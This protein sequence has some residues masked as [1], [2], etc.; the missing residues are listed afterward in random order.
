MFDYNTI[1][2]TVE[3]VVGSYTFL[4]QEFESTIRDVISSIDIQ[5]LLT[6]SIPAST[7]QNSISSALSHVS[8]RALEEYDR[9][10]NLEFR[11]IADK[12][13]NPLTSLFSSLAI[14]EVVAAPSTSSTGSRKSDKPKT[15]RLVQPVSA[16][17]DK[18]MVRSRLRAVLLSKTLLFRTPG[19]PHV[20]CDTIRCE[21][22]RTLFLTLN[23]TKCVGHK[24]CHST[25]YYPHIGTALWSMTK[26]RHAKGLSCKVRSK[27][28]GPHEIE[29]L[30]TEDPIDSESSQHD[31]ELRLEEDDVLGQLPG[32]KRPRVVSPVSV[33]SEPCAYLDWSVDVE[34]MYETRRERAKSESRTV[35]SPSGCSSTVE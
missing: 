4:L 12:L 3:V 33:R 31:D 24:A 9:T 18:K 22:C 21:F 6:N 5:L 11:S 2:N 8:N 1:R 20:K 28:C 7:I 29:A 26:S 17:V 30:N 15:K 25:G 27:A 35:D 34:T 13:W 23:I 10:Q 32:S 19:H 14:K 16:D